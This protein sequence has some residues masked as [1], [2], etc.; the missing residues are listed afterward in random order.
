MNFRMKIPVFF[1]LSFWFIHFTHGQSIPSEIDTSA[2]RDLV[3][4]EGFRLFFDAQSVTTDT[5]DFSQIISVDFRKNKEIH[6]F[7]Q[8]FV[9]RRDIVGGWTRTS[10]HTYLQG[11]FDEERFGGIYYDSESRKR[12]FEQFY[13]YKILGDSLYLYSAED[14]SRL[15]WVL[16]IL[17]LNDSFMKFRSKQFGDL[18]YDRT[19]FVMT[20]MLGE[21]VNRFAQKNG[22]L[23]CGD[24]PET[25]E[26]CDACLQLSADLVMG[27]SARFLK[28][29]V[30]TTYLHEKAP[31]KWI[32]ND[33]QS[34]IVLEFEDGRLNRLRWVGVAGSGKYHFSEVYLGDVQTYVEKKF[35]KPSKV[36][37]IDRLPNAEWWHYDPFPFRIQIRDERVHIIELF[38]AENYKYQTD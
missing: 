24:Y 12:L 8:E 27:M 20:S 15:K 13:Y 3:D 35:G 25:P 38:W 31:D 21:N 18:K 28:Q 22:K 37:S 36:V 10:P 34:R 9:W 7:S 19:D 32:L 5:V 11:Y 16:K 26:S 23:L 33:E 2:I 17:E 4:K 30:D 6:L 29:N 14:K 1:F